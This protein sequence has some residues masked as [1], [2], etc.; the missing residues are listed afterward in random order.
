MAHDIL[1]TLVGAHA[2]PR[3]FDP[4]GGEQ[5]LRDA[6]SVFISAQELAGIDLLIDGAFNRY[7]PHH[8]ETDGKID[9]FIRQLRHIRTSLSRPEE[10][11]FEELTHLRFRNK[12]AGVVEGQVGDGTLNLERDFLR[13]RAL[14]K[15][16]LK[17]TATSP[18]M[19][20]RILVDR[21]YHT[22]EELVDALADVLAGQIRD[23][24]AEVVQID[25]EVLPGTPADGPWVAEALN[26]VF[27]VVQHKSALHM[28][29]GNYGGQVVQTQGSYAPLI[30]FINLLHVDHVLVEMTR[31][32]PEDLAALKDIKPSIGIGLGMIDVKSTL[33]ESPDAI[34]RSIEAAEKV[35]GPGRLKYVTADCGLWMHHRSIADG[36]MTNLV[37]GRDAFLADKS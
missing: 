12:P 2:V 13:A 33:I 3:W 16:P 36:K 34:A 9:Y 1:T 28:C 10:K 6:I 4:R 32:G 15:R 7:D 22:R 23:I 18:Y 30:D 11:K 29:F 21:H 35:L 14:T 20:A 31:R 5:M 24:D 25:E 8:P 17:F 27:A 37:R 26:R 19:L